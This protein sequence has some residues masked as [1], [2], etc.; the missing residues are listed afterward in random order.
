MWYDIRTVPVKVEDKSIVL[1]R[2]LVE[3]TR[4]SGLSGALMV[5]GG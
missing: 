4:A 5:W 3:D 2:V 1:V